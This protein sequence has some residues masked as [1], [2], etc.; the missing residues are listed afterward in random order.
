MQIVL[1][2]TIHIIH[3]PCHSREQEITIFFTLPYVDPK[4]VDQLTQL[5]VA[6]DH[7]SSLDR[8][9]LT[10]TEKGTGE[11]HRQEPLLYCSEDAQQNATVYQQ[12]AA[13]FPFTQPWSTI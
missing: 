6:T 11:T 5:C 7:V 12:A 10:R 1:P 13:E 4:L 9:N 8:S 2:G 3:I